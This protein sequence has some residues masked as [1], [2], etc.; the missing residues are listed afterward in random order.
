M[1]RQLRNCV[2]RP[3]TKLLPC[4]HFNRLLGFLI[5]CKSSALS[6]FFHTQKNLHLLQ[7]PYVHDS[8]E[9]LRTLK[10]VHASLIVSYGHRLSAGAVSLLAPLYAKFDEIHHAVLLLSSLQEPCTLHWNRVLKSCVDLGLVESAFCVYKRMREDG[11]SHDNYTLPIVNRAV[12][13]SYG[14]NWYGKSIHGLSFKISLDLDVYFCNTLIESYTKSGGLVDA[15]KVFEGMPQRDMVSWTSIISGLVSQ[16]AGFEAFRLF[17]EMK[18]EIPPNS[19]TII[20]VLKA[21]SRLLECTQIHC[22]VIKNG[23]LIDMSI[24][25][26]IMKCYSNVFSVNEAEALFT[27]L[28]NADVVS[29]NIIISLYSLT[30]EVEKMIYCFGKM[31]AEVEPSVETLTTLVS[32]LSSGGHLAQGS[33]IHCLSLKTGLLDDILKSSL[34]NFYAKCN[35]V[36]RSTR[37]FGEIA[38]KNSVVWGAMMNGLIENGHFKEAVEVFLKMLASGH[39]PV[40]ENLKNLVIAYSNMGALQ[41]GKGVHGYL[42]RNMLFYTSDAA[43]NSLKTSILNMY[44]KCGNIS[45]ARICFDRMVSPRD[46]VAWTSMIEGYGTHGLGS[47]AVRLFHDMSKEGTKPNSVTFLSLLSACSHSGLLV[48]GVEIFHSMKTKFGVEP[49]LNHY[50]C[51]V[52]LLGR[53]GKVKEALTMV[54]KLVVSPDSMAWG[55]LL[56]AASRTDNYKK[57]AEYACERIVGLEPDNAGYYTLYSNV[58]ASSERWD[59]VECIRS[60]MKHKFSVKKPGWSC[61]EAGGMLHGFISGD[62]SHPQIREIHQV[63]ISFSRKMV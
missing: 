18:K 51:I 9:G 11:I 29:W 23:L 53:L 30:G 41:L 15:F 21:C 49:D 20:V 1:Q 31:L 8:R 42:I 35:D 56:S 40:F 60:F 50:T 33:Q 25:N 61:I 12:A 58:Q 52:D 34:L 16:G 48:E 46:I 14:S 27:E 36:E 24:K 17:R 54:M 43:D 57:V 28:E 7:F 10:Q 63:L 22:Y 19:V 13:L 39:K 45:T 6:S 37:L 62:R 47:E 2:L 4:L 59:E 5:S 26:S 55:A 3:P 32:G 44:I 38:W